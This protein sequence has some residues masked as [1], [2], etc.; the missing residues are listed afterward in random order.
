MKDGERMKGSCKEPKTKKKGLLRR[1][2]GKL[3]F[4]LEL[5]IGNVI[6]LLSVC[7]NGIDTD[8]DCKLYM[9]VI[10]FRLVSL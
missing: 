5:G 9:C 1:W 10:F 2:T 8:G 7:L 4:L 3:P 6:F